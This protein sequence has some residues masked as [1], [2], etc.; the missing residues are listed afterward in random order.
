MSYINPFRYPVEPT[1]KPFE[2]TFNKG[3]NRQC[4]YTREEAQT[5]AD[6]NKGEVKE[7]NPRPF[8]LERAR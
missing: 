6:K 4:F 2:V 3:R 8:K 7:I 1:L 5:F